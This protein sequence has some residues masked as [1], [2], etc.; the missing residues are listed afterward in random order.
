MG[1]IRVK[2][3][4]TNWM[5]SELAAGG[6]LSQLEVRSCEV[7]AVVD[8]GAVRSIIPIAVVDRLGVRSNRRT[9]AQYA[10]GR[11]DAV[12][13]T[14]PILFDIGSRATIETAMVLG[15]EV[16]I[17]Q[18][19]LET[20]DLLADCTNRRLVPNPEHPD[21]PVFKVRRSR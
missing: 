11:T 6:Q 3:R 9:V 7:D 1:E 20:T 21:Q 12:E 10:D 17:G 8:T 19:T 5:D 16:L 14:K 15:D 18:T 13:L 4:L 2:V